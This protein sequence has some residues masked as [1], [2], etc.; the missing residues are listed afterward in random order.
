MSAPTQHPDAAV[1]EH[2]T[3]RNRGL[4]SWITSDAVDIL[5]DDDGILRAL[6]A[7]DVRVSGQVVA[8]ILRQ[9]NGFHLITAP[10][11]RV[12]VNRQPV[13]AADLTQ[14]DVIE[15]EENGPLSR[16][17]IYDAQHHRQSSLSDILGDAESYL[18]TSRRPLVRRL[19]RATGMVLSR[20]VTS[21]SILFRAGVVIT[22]GVLAV[23][24][25][26]Q[27]FSDR[28]LQQQIE[29]GRLQVDALASALEKAQREA[30][31]PGDLNALQDEIG[32]RLRVN[33]ERI[34]TLEDQSTAGTRV[35][36]LATGSVVFL[37]GG[38]GL[39]VRDSG[40]MLRHVLGRDGSRLIY[41]N[42]QPVLSPDGEGPVAEA[43][44]TGTGFVLRGAGVIVTNR[45]VAAP[46]EQNSAL[47]FGGD[48]L[49]PVLTRF[50]GYIPGRPDA[51]G[52]SILA[53][54][55]TADL[56]LVVPADISSLPDGLDLAETLPVPGQEVL[57]MGYP[58]GLMSM[59]ARS[60]EQFVEEM[61]LSGRTGFWEVAEQL[62]A[63]GLMW[64]LS[65]RGIVGQITQASVV[66]DAETTHG[67]S[68]G[69]VLNLQGQV[70]AVNTAI[71]PDFGGSNLGVPVAEVRALLAAPSQ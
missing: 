59:L 3:G 54:S 18:R 66:Y 24:A 22:L 36:S 32:V 8:R 31:R 26:W 43:Q 56:A 42:G 67:G 35:V 64:P 14:G 71:L 49:E 52:L 25:G 5:L 38:Y 11:A 20:V 2:L 1:L 16:I 34:D 70:V 50:I 33:A 65:S 7:G 21:P 41:P 63:A 58:T 13:E 6:A 53:L 55:D 46:W 57:V 39:R 61:R 40:Q 47:Q 28:A 9:K 68:G 45:H 27:Y 30:I 12:W 19:A 62:A 37:Q 29:G 48:T 51:I 17:R 60:G 10:R 23:F 15:F 44:V 69:P 4:Y